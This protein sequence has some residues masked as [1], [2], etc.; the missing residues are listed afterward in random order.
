MIEPKYATVI[1][2]HLA[3]VVNLIE[4]FVNAL[5]TLFV[6]TVTLV[7]VKLSDSAITVSFRIIPLIAP[8]PNS[9]T[10]YFVILKIGF[11]FWGAISAAVTLELTIFFLIDKALLLLDGYFVNPAKYKVLFYSMVGA[12]MLGTVTIMGLLAYLEFS[13]GGH[14]ILSVFPIF[15]LL[16]FI[17]IGVGRWKDR[18]DKIAESEKLERKQ[19]REAKRLNQHRGAVKPL[20]LPVSPNVSPNGDPIKERRKAVATYFKENG[21]KS[22]QD[23]ATHLSIT[24]K[25]T[26]YQDVTWLIKRGVME[27]VTNN[28]VSGLAVN[29]KFDDFM[30]G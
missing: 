26:V 7:L 25:G 6:D 8:V 12:V 9:I 15:S 30:K 10:V 18:Q 4:T 13:D 11:G 1:K 20:D 14:P 27:K 28:G 16:A 2:H 22:Y 5:V 21:N 17:G 24:N 19:E 3:A 23:A 29:G